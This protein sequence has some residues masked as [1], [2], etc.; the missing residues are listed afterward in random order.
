MKKQLYDF[1]N[2]LVEKEQSLSTWSTRSLVV[3]V[4]EI[5]I[6]MFSALLLDEDGGDEA[7]D[8]ETKES[9][10]EGIDLDGLG[11]G[12]NLSLAWPVAR[13]EKGPCAG[14]K[15]GA[16]ERGGVHHRGRLSLLRE[17]SALNGHENGYDPPAPGF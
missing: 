6:D 14:E 1:Q 7:D 5:H 10:E 8:E 13:V 11:V 9:P 16:D 12:Q 15:V 4:I 3:V 17:N 2:F